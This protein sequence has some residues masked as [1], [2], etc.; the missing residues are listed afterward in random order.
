MTLKL[1]VNR[2]TV[3]RCA[4]VQAEAGEPVSGTRPWSRARSMQS[5]L[6]TTNPNLSHPSYLQKISEIVEELIG[7]GELVVVDSMLL[8]APKDAIVVPKPRSKPKGRVYTRRKA[9]RT[10]KVV[11]LDDEI[12]ESNETSTGGWHDL[13]DDTDPEDK[14][15]ERCIK[16]DTGQSNGWTEIVEVLCDCDDPKPDDCMA[17]VD[18]NATLENLVAS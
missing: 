5:A 4:V 2:H 12:T 1:K 7:K 17:H 6:V 10:N 13:P 14:V 3:R 9:G 11:R 16:N 15:F 18:P 8:P